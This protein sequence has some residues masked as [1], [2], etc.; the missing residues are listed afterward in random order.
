MSD[1]IFLPLS[2]IQ[3]DGWAPVGKST[4][5]AAANPSLLLSHDDDT[6]YASLGSGGSSNIDLIFGTDSNFPEQM[7]SVSQVEVFARGRLLSGGPT[8][9]ALI[10][11]N[12]DGNQ[13]TTSFA[14][15]TS[16]ATRQM[17]MATAP[18]GGS[19]T[20]AR[21]RDPSFGFGFG[22]G[23]GA[24]P[25][26][27]R[28]TSCWAVATFVAQ[29]TQF[30]IAPHLI[31]AA[32]DI[33]IFRATPET[34]KVVVPYKYL[35]LEVMDSVVLSHDSVARAAS[36]LDSISDHM[37]IDVWRGMYSQIVH[38]DD[39]MTSMELTITLKNMDRIN[40][41]LASTG[42]APF[43]VNSDDT[44][45][46]ISQRRLGVASI[47]AG[48]TRHETRAELAYI[49]DSSARYGHVRLAKVIWGVAKMNHLGT[50]IESAAPGN[51]ID[52]SC[53]INALAD[54]TLTT[55]TGSIAVSTDE[56]LFENFEDFGQQVV[57]VTRGSGDTYFEQDITTTA[58]DRRVLIWAKLGDVDGEW[59]FQRNN[60]DYW[61]D[62]S[63]S[64]SA[65]AV[66]NTLANDNDEWTRTVSNV[67]TGQ[68]AGTAT[69]YVGATG[70]E[71]DFFYVGQLMSYEDDNVIY[72]DVLTDGSTVIAGGVADT[73]YDEIDNGGSDERQVAH[74]DHGTY[75]VTLHAYQ[76]SDAIEEGT[77]NR[78]VLATA[79][80]DADN[81]RD[82]ISLEKVSSQVR[83]AYRRFISGSE[84]A[85]AYA[86]FT[87]TRGTEYEIMCR[88]TS[89][90]EGELGLAAR[91]LSVLV[92]G[93]KGTDDQ[94]SGIHSTSEQV[95]QFYHGSTTSGI[96]L[97]HAGNYLRN[98]EVVQRCI[99]DE[100]AL[101]GR[102]T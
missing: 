96:G 99:P 54:Y 90:S 44:I 94:A 23:V 102:P 26:E 13:T 48:A 11:C 5:Y 41:L 22:N 83:I 62:S 39:D 70:L 17:P 64:W 16:Y 40:C 68:G 65:S 86:D 42:A 92:D 18:G 75:R 45:A 58:V 7:A 51:D 49:P 37:M 76:D 21:L 87:L 79:R 93:T 84:D 6:T 14:L 8:T 97:K 80:W 50:L 60:G 1:K 32:V 81:D 71:N 91:T 2:I 98:W 33:R 36:I 12:Y 35:D 15:S 77:D 66:W 9:N 69:L 30:E 19:W 3:D 89:A 34:Y 61:N 59:A 10:I 55:S 100:E 63:E 73:I 101:G 25:G 31:V 38:I 52:S 24:Q 95:T 88:W 78:H 20:E 28:V 82:E 85:L 47:S 46:E 27:M 29:A 74:P 56:Q 67:I 43:D 53:F 57:K 4:E 72:S